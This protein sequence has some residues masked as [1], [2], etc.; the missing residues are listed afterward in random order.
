MTTDT[1]MT[2]DIGQSVD[3]FTM[4]IIRGALDAI[5]E[6]MFV[7]YGRAAQGVV[8]YETLDMAVGYLNARGESVAQGCGVPSFISTL[9]AATQCVLARFAAAEINP[10]DVF[11]VNDP[12]NGGGTHMSDVAVVVPVILDGEIVGFTAN[13]GHWTELGGKDPGTSTI[14]STDIWQEGLQLPCVKIIAQGELNTAVRDIIAANVRTPSQTLGDMWAAIAAA[15]VGERRVKELIG[16]HGAATFRDAAEAM[17]DYAERMT[18]REIARLPQG[19]FTAQDCI[20]DDGFHPDVP[21]PIQVKVTVAGEEIAF[22]FSGSN[23]QVMG[24]FNTSRTGLLCGARMGLLF[25][26]SKSV[27]VNAGC[28]RPLR[29]LCPDGTIFTARHPAPVSRYHEP[30]LGACDLVLKALAPAMPD[31]LAAGHLLS[32]C[33]TIVTSRDPTTGNY[34]VLV[35]PQA[36][37]WGAWPGQDGATGLFCFGDGDTMNV[38]IEVAET[39]Y[40]FLVEEYSILPE[41]G[42]AGTWRGGNA[43]VRSLLITR[44]GTEIAGNFGRR[45]FPPWGLAGGEDGSPNYI[46]IIRADGRAEQFGRRTRVAL[47][48]GDRVRLVTA[49]GGGYGPPA[50]RSREAVLRDVRNGLVAPERARAVYGLAADDLA[51][52]MG[53]A[54]GEPE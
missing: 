52:E 7:A 39:R 35:E 42:G 43:M 40:G 46:E 47:E 1:Q 27:P 15:R 30:M 49:A 34:A 44:A 21:L 41:I 51:P 18:R 11:L 17:L 5:C 25:L 9:D 53:E 3:P 19:V 36:G 6:E 32:V 37:G 8:I 31:V 33:T 54:N 16:K 13:K 23:P 2:T 45:R 28:F 50:E 38:P 12:F 10:G 4:E 29:V 22:D 14:N 20:D 24:P 48:V 26:L